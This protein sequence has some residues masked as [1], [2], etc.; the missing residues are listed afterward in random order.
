MSTL[1]DQVAYPGLVYPFATPDRLS[2]FGALFGLGSEN[3]GDATI[4]ELGCGDGTNLL[5]IAQRFPTATVI[6]VDLSEQALSLARQRAAAAGLNQVTFLRLDLAALGDEG[7]GTGPLPPCDYLIA[8]GLMSWVAPETRQEILRLVGRLLKPSGVA[9]L[10]FLT[11]PGQH[12][13]E[14]LRG[15]MR[16]HVKNVSDPNK[17]IAQARDIALWQYERMKKLHGDARA[18]LLYELVL[19]WHQLPDAVFLHDLLAEERHPLTLTAFCDEAARAGLS[20]LANAR[21]DEPRNELLP[22][23][24]REFVAA[25][26][27]PVRRQSYLDAFLMTRFRTSLFHRLDTP[28]KRGANASTFLGFFATSLIPRR[29]VADTHTVVVSTG[30]G[31]I[32]LSPEATRLLRV[33]ADHR[34]H[35]LALAELASHPELADAEAPES[36][37]TIGVAA[38]QLWLAGAIELT[39]S[40]PTLASAL[41]STPRA[42]PLA[43]QLAASGRTSSP[44]LWHRELKLPEEA[45]PLLAKA[46]GQTPWPE[47]ARELAEALFDEGAFIP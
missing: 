12:D 19:E 10:S 24:L 27:D 18:R 11:F 33:L 41:S 14:P 3:P 34:P 7:V 2:V 30:V 35:A 29:E 21:M 32:R 36:H 40:P 37:E 43:R 39:R 8:H 42:T 22:E 23:D 38:S 46:D 16:H 17:R 45:L 44:T 20:W 6:G 47:S 26:P 4:L 25:I 5:S 1:Y 13:I 31:Q 15:L 28:A 9:M